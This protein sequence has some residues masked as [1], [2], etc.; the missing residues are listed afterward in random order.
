[1]I[2]Q[3]L[4]TTTASGLTSSDISTGGRSLMI[5]K[6]FSESW[7]IELNLRFCCQMIGFNNKY[8]YFK[9]VVCISSSNCFFFFFFFENGGR[10]PKSHQL[11]DFLIIFQTLSKQFFNILIINIYFLHHCHF[12]LK[13]CRLTFF[14]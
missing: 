2:A 12:I 1:M 9:V 7:L 10:S 13:S 5:S 8:G 3:I 6:I 4:V 11:F 14:L